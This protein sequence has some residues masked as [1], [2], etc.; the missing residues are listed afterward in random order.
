MTHGT[1]TIS[2]EHNRRK[3]LLKEILRRGEC[4]QFLGQYFYIIPRLCLYS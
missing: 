2:I 4:G 1:E 3:N